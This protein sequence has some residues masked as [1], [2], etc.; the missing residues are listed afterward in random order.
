M[1]SINCDLGE[2]WEAYRSG[3]QERW[4]QVADLANVACGAHAGDAE[5]TQVTMEQV[6]RVGARAGA[7][8]GYADR[9]NFGRQAWFGSKLNARQVSEMVA[10]QVGLAQRAA[11]A[12]GLRL[13]H[14][15]PH[16]ALYNQASEASDAGGELAE[17]IARGVGQVERD[18]F[19]VGL[20]GSQMLRVFRRMGYAVLREAFADRAYTQAGLLVPRGEPGAMLED[21]KEI[22][23]QVRR[24]QGSVDTF[25][26]HG[27]SQEA[28]GKLQ[29]L[30]AI[31]QA[32]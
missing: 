15:K 18:V 9:E 7:H 30:R 6:A 13:Y 2:S 11:Q 22:S 14:V 3:E 26:V 31:L 21:E 5:L 23:E 1:A 24:L 27:D 20:A 19:L 32:G 4:L 10:E 25:C 29:L 17:A 28:Y 16:G 12:A 8:P